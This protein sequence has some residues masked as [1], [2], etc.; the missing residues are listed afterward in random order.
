MYSNHGPQK[1]KQQRRREK[2][3]VEWREQKKA[4]T[5]ILDPYHDDF[6]FTFSSDCCF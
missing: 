5:D 4:V 3:F 1:L 6:L 2:T